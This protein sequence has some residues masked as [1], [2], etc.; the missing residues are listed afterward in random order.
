MAENVPGE[1]TGGMGH[2]KPPLSEVAKIDITEQLAELNPR[3]IE[4][5]QSFERRVAAGC[6]DRDE[7][8]K[9]ADVVKLLAKLDK[10]VD[11][12]RGD[13]KEPYLEATQVVDAAAKVPRSQIA[14]MTKTLKALIK[15]FE[16]AEYNREQE[17]QRKAEAERRQQEA[18][19]RDR[20]EQ[21]RKQR[22][23]DEAAA[24]AAGV[25]LAPA[26][27]PEPVRNEAPPEAEEKKPKR[28]AIGSGDYGAAAHRTVRK[29]PQIEDVYALPPEV[30]NAPRVTDAILT[31]VRGLR[32]ANPDIEIQG[33]KIV[34]DV[35]VSIR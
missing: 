32:T 20:D 12:V 19:Q 34:N 13:V 8:G 11:N 16:L 5:T 31:V 3:L 29:V 27:E 18:A 26:P 23:A 33:I 7:V 25:K 21:D 30:L 28:Q 22:L 15:A 14:E 24:A 1:A 35:G 17:E 10:R 6:K 4:L 2:N 9:C